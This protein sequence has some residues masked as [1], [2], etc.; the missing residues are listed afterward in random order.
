MDTGHALLSGQLP[1]LL[2]ELVAHL[3]LIQVHN[4]RGHFEDHR[5]QTITLTAIT[6][7][8]LAPGM[9]AEDQ[10]GGCKCEKMNKH[11][12]APTTEAQLSEGQNQQAELNKLVVEMNGNTGPKKLEAMAAIVTRL[13][14]QLNANATAPASKIS[15][16][17]DQPAAE[18]HHH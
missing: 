2:D 17:H 15:A 6:I 18:A 10:P 1:N 9:F 3:C 4:N 14:D 13:V 11:E 5:F 8:L 16:A 12:P 7:A